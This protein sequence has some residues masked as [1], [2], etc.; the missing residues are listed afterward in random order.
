VPTG[1]TREYP[2]VNP[3]TGKNLTV[4]IKDIKKLGALTEIATAIHQ[5]RDFEL[6]VTGV[7]LPKVPP[8]TIDFNEPY[9]IGITCHVYS[10]LRS[11]SDPH[12]EP[13]SKEKVIPYRELLPEMV[14][15]G[16]FNNPYNMKPIN[17]S[18]LRWLFP[19][20]A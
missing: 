14:A 11:T 7:G 5:L 6:E 17:K 8:L 19:L 2:Y 16:Y 12:D 9:H 1:K 3:F 20:L 13:A 4:E 10:Q 15:E 18:T